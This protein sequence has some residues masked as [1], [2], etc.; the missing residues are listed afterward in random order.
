M[1][2]EKGEKDGD[3]DMQQFEQIQHSGTENRLLKSSILF[4]HSLATL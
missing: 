2:V 3:E 1:E 4:L